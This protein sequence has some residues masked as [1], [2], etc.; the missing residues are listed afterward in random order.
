[1]TEAETTTVTDFRDGSRNLHFVHVNKTR[2]GRTCRACHE[3]HASRRPNH[4]RESVP[5]GNWQLPVNYEKTDD[6]GSC[7]PGCHRPETYSRTAGNA[8]R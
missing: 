4:I 2:K 3:T 5:F 1:M 8:S 6:G 7:A